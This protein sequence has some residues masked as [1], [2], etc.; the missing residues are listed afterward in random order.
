MSIELTS[1]AFEHDGRIP[2][3]HARSGEDVSPPLR[4]SGVPEGTQ[5]LAL[6]VR[7]PDAP[8]GTFTHWLV[9]GLSP[10]LDGLEAGTLPEG[11]RQGRNDFGDVGY[12][13][14]QPPAGEQHRYV[15]SL[16]ALRNSVLLAPDDTYEVFHDAAQ[17]AEIGR[18][19][20]VGRYP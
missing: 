19:E 20:L 17:G 18:G 13:G 6:V 5:E 12:G 1:P 14:P 8:Q 7:D 16:L 3:R 11:A 10:D 4:W 15:F 2:D 9:T